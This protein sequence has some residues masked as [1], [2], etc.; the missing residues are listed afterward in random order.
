MA[1]TSA[2]DGALCP[3][4]G[5]DRAGMGQATCGR[6]WC[7]I[8]H[9]DRLEVGGELE[10]K[11]WS[12]SEIEQVTE[13]L[14]A[15]DAARREGSA[16]QMRIA[17]KVYVRFMRDPGLLIGL[18]ERLLSAEKPPP[19]A[20]Q[21]GWPNTLLG[22]HWRAS[23]TMDPFVPVLT[24]DLRYM[25]EQL[26]AW[27]RAHD[28]ASALDLLAKLHPEASDRVAWLTTPHRE[29][30]EKP[31]LEILLSKPEVVRD[32]LAASLMGIPT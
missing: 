5:G 12:R 2:G 29:L 27:E 31:P 1:W 20:P 17:A 19:R 9:A 18:L 14:R 26:F 8:V 10:P 32:M 11:R 25:V 13:H 6:L 24:N 4:C 16:E 22:Y 3:V 15:I 28:A 7:T 30:D 21:G 23:G